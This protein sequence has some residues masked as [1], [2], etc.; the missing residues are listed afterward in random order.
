MNRFLTTI[1]FSTLF[2]YTLALTA[3]IAAE[4]VQAAVWNADVGVQ[5]TDEGNQGLGFLPSEL[6]IH[7][8]DSI[9]WRFPTAELHTVSFLTAGQIRPPFLPVNVGC[10]G[11]TPDGSSV[12][13]AACVNSGVLVSGQT[14]TVTFPT[15]GNFKLV[16]LVHIR[17]SGA[18]HVL[19]LAE[20]LPH[21]QAFYDRQAQNGRAE[22]LSDASRLADRG[23]AT[24]QRT[25]GGSEE[26]SEESR[27]IGTSE[28]EVTAGIAEVVATTGG[29]SSTAAVM[30]FLGGTTTVHAGDTVEWTNLGPV[31]FH[32]VTFGTEPANLMP[33][34]AG[35]T[36]DPDGARHAVIGSPAANVNSGFL[37]VA[38]QDRVGLAQSP[39]DVTRFRVTFTAPGIFNYI[40]GL[41]DFLG[42][43]GRVVVLP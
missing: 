8:G 33:P 13:G 1:R 39:L 11:T 43:V 36:V 12:T 10:L 14:Y 37:G 6:W 25:F 5:S 4:P 23:L 38:T 18:V 19:S 9:A 35:V 22:M 16:C 21:D 24:A 42:M 41:H 2:C 30:R 34:S 27:A 15:P 40:C 32:T 29:G 26:D 17:M 31:V 20:T 28:H 7:A 3:L